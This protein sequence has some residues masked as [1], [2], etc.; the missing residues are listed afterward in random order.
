MSFPG[1]GEDAPLDL[2]G[3]TDAGLQAVTSRLLDG[4]FDAFAETAAAVK[5]C[6]RP[7]RLTGRSHTFELGTRRGH[8]AAVGEHLDSFHSEHAPLGV[9]YRPCGNRRA[10]VCPSCSRTY[11]RDTFAMIDAGLSGGKTVSAT[12]AEN[13]LLFAT[14]TAPSFGSHIHRHDKAGKPCRPDN[15]DKGARCPHGRPYACPKVHAA[16]EAVVG[17]PFCEDC[18]DWTTAV[19]WQWWAPELWRR[20]TIELKRALAKHLDVPESRL[21]ERASVQFVKVAEYQTRGMVHFHALLRLDGTD[22]PGSPA[23]LDGIKLA[24]LLQKAVRKVRFDAPPI[25]YDGVTRRLSWGRQLDIRIIRDGDRTDDPDA[26]LTPG[27]VAG[28]LAKYASKDV[29]SVRLE[30]TTRPH[31]A[32]MTSTC[33]DL[34]E[35]ASEFYN[36][37]CE[38]NPYHLIRKWSHMLGFRGHFSTKSRRYSIT[39]G[40]LRRA[41]V[42]YQQMVA[43]A[44]RNGESLEEISTA[45]LEARLLGE[46]DETTLVIGEWAYQGTGWTNPGDEALALAAAARAREY[47]QWKSQTKNT[48]QPMRGTK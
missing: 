44:R 19:V 15:R 45:E 26:V 39:L 7:V 35:T 42:R 18:Q 37:L 30:D 36:G 38:P 17:A 3:L 8:L 27:Q 4:T 41:R 13:P 46:E 28:Y 1:Y 24:E 31:L 33:H 29:S 23:P 40:R 48:N 12:V 20:T 21:K 34:A 43:D 5:N 6:A 47:D 10:D 32:R 2:S 9:L 25:D 22:G 11:A 14:L 16:D